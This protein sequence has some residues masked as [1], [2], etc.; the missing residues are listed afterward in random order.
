MHLKETNTETDPDFFADL[1]RAHGATFEKLDM[2]HPTG[3]QVGIYR[4]PG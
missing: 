1:G 3:Q 4:Y 2:P